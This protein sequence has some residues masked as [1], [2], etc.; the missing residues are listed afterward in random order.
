MSGADREAGLTLV[1]LLVATAV[2]A[3]IA[4]VLV[5]ALTVGWSTTDDTV[6][7]L[8]ANRD[9]LMT[10]SLLTRDVQGARTVTTTGAGCLQTGDT[11]V[12]RF[13]WVDT[14]AAGTAVAKTAAWVVTNAVP[15]VLERR[16]CVGAATLTSTVTTSH[17]V[18]AA[19][20]ACRNTAAGG[21]V[22]CSASTSTV[23]LTV[24]DSAAATYTATGRRRLP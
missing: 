5:G 1:E 8:G 19:T 11:L 4:P 17:D 13:T 10:S 18:S 22:S 20:A 15:K 12:V 9:R 14:D 16:Y 7:R 24:T 2:T 6:T 23:T 3:V 21:A